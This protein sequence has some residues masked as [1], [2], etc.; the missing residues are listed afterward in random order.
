MNALEDTIKEGVYDLVT[1]SHKEGGRNPVGSE[2]RKRDGF[3]GKFT[4]YRT[5]EQ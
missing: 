3:D 5:F 1:T 2:S 4:H